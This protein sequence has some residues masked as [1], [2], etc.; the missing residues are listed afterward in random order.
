MGSKRT[1]R[2]PRR[3][4]QARATRLAILEAAHRLFT[5]DGYTATTMQAVAAKADVATKTV[6]LAFS[7]KAA[8]RSARRRARVVHRHCPRA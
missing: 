3:E 7:T 2:S 6:Y 1:Y 5:S 4:Q 8:R